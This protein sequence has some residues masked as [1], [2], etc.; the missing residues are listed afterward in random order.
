M[1]IGGKSHC[2]NANWYQLVH[3]YD[4]TT[5]SLW[6]GYNQSMIWLLS[7]S[8]LAI[9]SQWYDYY[10]S[11]HWPFYVSDM[12]TISLRTGH[13][14]SVIWLLSVFTLAIL[15]LWCDY[16]QSPH[17]PFYVSDMTT[18]SLRTGHSTPTRTSFSANLH[19]EIATAAA[20]LARKRKVGHSNPSR[21]R[22]IHGQ[23][24]LTIIVKLT[25]T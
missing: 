14:T 4:M 16:Y 1:A 12:T 5:I 13:S 22:P 20:R 10:Q 23:L 17:W 7:V 2:Q 6:Y 3:V 21:D 19:I 25:L 9:L 11:P 18:I 15:R 8:A 24:C